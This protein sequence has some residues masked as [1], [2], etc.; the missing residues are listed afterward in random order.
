MKFTRNLKVLEKF[1]NEM[2][3]LK[4]SENQDIKPILEWIKK[5]KKK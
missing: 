4:K 1:K 2:E 3:R 5:D